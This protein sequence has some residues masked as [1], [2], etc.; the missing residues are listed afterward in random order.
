M[1]T[2]FKSDKE[3]KFGMNGMPNTSKYETNVQSISI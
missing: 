3:K 2:L 1:V